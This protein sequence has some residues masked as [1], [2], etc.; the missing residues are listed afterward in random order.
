MRL[1]S[2]SDVSNVPPIRPFHTRKPEGSGRYGR[3][4]RE[5]FRTS[6]SA[7]PAARTSSDVTHPSGPRLWVTALAAQSTQLLL[8]RCPVASWKFE[9][10]S[11]LT[12]LQISTAR[13]AQL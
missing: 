2:G 12:I 10:S 6:R 5:R 8:A 9:P 13:Y 7:N 11:P 1:C 3:G 4:S